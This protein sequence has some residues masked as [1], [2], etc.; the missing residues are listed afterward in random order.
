MSEQPR[1][2]PLDRVEPGR[3]GRIRAVA[4]GDDDV[5]RL[6][7][8]GVCLGRHVMLVRRGDPLILRVVGSRIGVS[9]RLASRVTVDPCTSACANASG[10]G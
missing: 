6:M 3:C 4:A 2:I 9:A 1:E 5:E 7:S 8:M 10:S